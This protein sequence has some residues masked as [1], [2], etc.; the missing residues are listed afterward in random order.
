MP[1]FDKLKASLFKTVT[2]HMGYRAA[3]LSVETGVLV[4][5]SLGVTFK[6]PTLKEKQFLEWDE[7]AYYP[8]NRIMEYME[9]DFSGLYDLVANSNGQ[10]RQNVIIQENEAGTDLI[11]PTEYRINAVRR[12]FDGSV[13][14]AWLT[15]IEL[16]EEPEE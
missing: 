13:V 9:P 12:M 11:V 5:E 1:H 10:S 2:K 14:Y 4:P 6:Y 3:W 16:V 8:P 15:P 7:F